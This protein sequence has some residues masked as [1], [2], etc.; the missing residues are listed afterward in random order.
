M[1]SKDLQSRCRST[2]YLR[3]IPSR[4]EKAL[5]MIMR[6]TMDSL[7]DSASYM[8]YHYSM[9]NLEILS[10]EPPKVLNFEKK[11]GN[12]C[13]LSQTPDISEYLIRREL[14]LQR[15]ASH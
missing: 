9:E 8:A 6:D 10:I 12:V 3:K 15:L 5:E 13:N 7:A 2:G 4:G 14:Q 1:S 11:R